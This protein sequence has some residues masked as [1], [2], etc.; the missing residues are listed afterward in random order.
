MRGK[1]EASPLLSIGSPLNKIRQ[2]FST[3]E[4]TRGFL[5]AILGSLF[6]YMQYIALDYPLITSISGVIALYLLL[7]S[8]KKVWLFTGFFTGM[9]W[10]WWISLS[11]IH[12]SMPWAVPIVVV[13]MGLLYALLFY[14]IAKLSQ[15]VE[16][17]KLHKYA[18]LPYITKALGLFVLSYIHPFG[19]DWF[20]PELMFVN[21][22]IGIE[23]WQFA[24]VLI[25]IV[26]TVIRK[27][28]LFLLP[29]L[30]AIEPNTSKIILSSSINNSPIELVETNTT[31]KDKWDESK[32]SEIYEEVF[33]FI[34]SAIESK[35]TLI[36][37]PESVF[38]IFLNYNKLL[39]DRLKEKS[40]QISIVV[41]GL[42]WDGKTPYNSTYIFTKNSVQIANKVVLVPF[43]ESNPLPDF[44]SDWVNE[45]FYDGAVDYKAD[46]KVTDY[47]VDGVTYRNAICFEA[48]SQKLYEKDSKNQRPRNMIVLSNNGWF[49]PSIEP[50][51][52]S[53]LL[54]YYSRKYKTTIYHS[55]NMSSS[56]VVKP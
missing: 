26:L 37:F 2:Y 38:P 23:K 54:L 56:Y 20:K 52:Q 32:H 47:V 24:I 8:S 43:G 3:L 30:L 39:V 6:I 50:T 46:S 48:T 14:S 29:I 17:S 7:N 21:S 25:S 40:K 12:Y 41:G 27:N 33:S 53:L 1:N 44:L 5:V 49:T 45:V 13:A 34:D 55:T 28:I 31:V 18:F 22:Y 10:F 4:I 42:F 35:K 19:F 15:I 9:F 51:L 36:V 16:N 11:F